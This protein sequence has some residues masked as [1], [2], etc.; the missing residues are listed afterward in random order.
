MKLS[1]GKGAI[2]CVLV[3]PAQI[4]GPYGS[5]LGACLAPSAG[6]QESLAVGNWESRTRGGYTVSFK[7]GMKTG[8]SYIA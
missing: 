5:A 1:A 7:G 3:N 2:T 4:M 8:L 6:T